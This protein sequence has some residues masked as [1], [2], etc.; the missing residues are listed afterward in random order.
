MSYLLSRRRHFHFGQ[1]FHQPD[2][3]GKVF[4]TPGRGFRGIDCRG[5]FG[6]GHRKAKLCCR[7]QN[8]SEIL[9]HKTNRKLRRV[10]VLFGGGANLPVWAGATTAV[11]ASVSKRRS[12]G[13]SS[14]EPN[15]TASAMACMPTPKS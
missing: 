11:L 13:R 15:A 10:V 2:D 5:R 3:G 8:Q 12:R 14:L 4:L 1:L 6:H 9:S 7:I